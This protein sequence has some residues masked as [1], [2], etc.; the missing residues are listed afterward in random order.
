MIDTVFASR[1]AH[2][3]VLG[4]TAFFGV[5]VCRL[6]FSSAAGLINFDTIQRLVFRVRLN[7]LKHINRLSPEFHESIPLGEKLYRIERDV[8][9]VAD[10]GS[11]FVPYVLRMMSNTIFVVVT[12]LILNLR[13][14]CMVL[15]L[16]PLFLVLK[17]RFRDALRTASDTAQQKSSRESSFLQE[18]LGALLQIQLLRRELTQTRSFVR[19]ASARVRALRDRKLTEIGFSLTCMMVVVLGTIL[20]L[21]YGGYEVLTGALTIGGFVAFYSYLGRLFDPMNAAVEIYAWLNRVRTSIRR[22][23]EICELIP[24][25]PEHSHAIALPERLPGTIRMSA[26]SFRYRDGRP[27]LQGVDLDIREGKEIDSR[28]EWKREEYDCKA[29]LAAL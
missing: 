4:G 26:V 15:P 19:L 12:M 9:Q 22:I 11:D 3:L 29:D 8:D 27:V 23:L 2:L 21:S 14:T 7:L 20:V 25:V 13:L 6:A 10:I 24:T 17:K 1:D 16:M 18:H 5:Y 28:P